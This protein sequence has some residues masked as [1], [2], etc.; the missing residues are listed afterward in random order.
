M[1][2]YNQNSYTESE[3]KLQE[4]WKEPQSGPGNNP[5]KTK[6]VGFLAGCET[7]P[8]YFAASNTP[9]YPVTRICY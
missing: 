2:W 3:R 1:S 4:P 7:E 6:H 5:G 8:N 9:R